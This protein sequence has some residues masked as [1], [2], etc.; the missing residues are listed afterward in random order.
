MTRPKVVTVTRA[1]R[2]LHLERARER[3]SADLL[4]AYAQAAYGGGL[5]A[6]LRALAAVFGSFVRSV[7]AESTRR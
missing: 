5:R 4:A 3:V 7:L 6:R 1:R 2:P